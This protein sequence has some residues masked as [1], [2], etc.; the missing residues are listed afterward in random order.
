[1]KLTFKSDNKNLCISLYISVNNE[2]KEIDNSNKEVCFEVSHD[3]DINTIVEYKADDTKENKNLIC[4]FFLFLLSLILSPI[5][6]F[7]ENEGGINNLHFYQDAN[8]FD[9]QK[10]FILRAIDDTITLKF[11][12]PKY[13]KLCKGFSQ[14]KIII[15]GAEI[16]KEESI[17]KYN[18]KSFKK[19]FMIYHYPA[20]VLIFT[21]ILLLIAIITFSLINLLSMGNTI[22]IVGLLFCLLFMVALL[23]IFIVLLIREHRTFKQINKNLINQSSLQFEEE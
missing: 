12:P 16:I 8:P 7:I 15:N 22:Q 14:P 11:I 6:F 17:V 1:M 21:F 23:A 3:N 2:K 5:V 9:I 10:N 20:Y 4:K 13:I 18:Q 19:E